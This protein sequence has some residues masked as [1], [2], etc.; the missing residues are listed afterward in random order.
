MKRTG[1]CFLAGVGLLLATAGCADGARTE[2][3]PA[4]DTVHVSCD[5]SFKPVIDAEVQVF[6]DTYPDQEIIVHYK[7]EADCLRDM[8]VD[9]IRL[10]IATRGFSERER[11]AITDSLKQGP[12]K[13]TIA[14]D[15][16]AVIVHP[17][18]RDSFFTM[19]QIR[20]VITGKYKENV[21][22]VFDGLKATSTVRFVL[23]SVLR[24]ESL[25][26]KAAAAAD[27]RGVIDY[28]SRTPNAIG[29]LGISWLGNPEDSLQ[30]SLL[31]KVR[32]AR[33]ESTDSAR[34]YVLPVQYLIYTRS[35]PMVRDLVYVW[36]EDQ[37]RSGKVFA[38]FLA[39]ERG[40]LI[41]KRAYLMPALRPY[42]VRQAELKDGE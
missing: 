19:E 31:R 20:Q 21:I 1:L 32:L 42:Y 12:Q 9:S 40:Q 16:I 35:Y 2:E 25:G 3:G 34:H 11:L 27:S 30:R 39:G 38:S 24:G 14:R 7:P 6:E 17:S 33:L 26:P 8:L 18:F 13:L 10:V 29:F 37:R 22:P 5:E 4:R 15:A 41:F 36:K 28:V 23:D